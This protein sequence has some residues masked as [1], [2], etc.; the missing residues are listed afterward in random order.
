MVCIESGS[1]S[2]VV[3]L[4]FEEYFLKGKDLGKNIFMLWQSEPAI[5]IGRFQNLWEETNFHFAEENNIQIVRR[6]SGGGAVYHDAG[7]V[8]FSF[9]LQN[10]T[11]DKFNKVAYIQPVVDALAKLGLNCDISQRNDL[12]IDGRKFCG[13]AMA[14]HQN[15]LL[16][17]G[18]LLFDTDLKML[19]IAL[20]KPEFQIESKGVKSVRSTVA[21]IK[22][23]FN[24]KKD[25]SEFKHE[26]AS[27]IKV[28]EQSD[29]CQLSAEDRESIQTLSREKYS[30]W[31]WNYATSPVTT[32]TQNAQLSGRQINILIELKSGVIIS[33]QFSGDYL[34][35]GEADKIRKSLTGVRYM[36]Q[37][38]LKELNQ[39]GLPE[40]YETGA[41]ISLA[42]CIMGI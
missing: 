17:H 33:S 26:L 35:A 28:D 21:N 16:F 2:L 3:N 14:Y 25:V 13:N 41:D 9:I 19:E 23:Y 5:V 29:D 24:S 6:I 36:Y 32:I 37:D 10:V 42:R 18:T 27:L 39:T 20:R 40:L 8:C 22:P 34:R 30:S 11:P 15:R 4:A 7:T 1:S 38:V 31:E 12:F